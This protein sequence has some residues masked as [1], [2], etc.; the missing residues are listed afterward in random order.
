MTRR[1]ELGQYFTP[2]PVAAFA[3]DALEAFGLAGGRLRV[4]DPA[5]GEGVFLAEALRR[6]PAARVWGCDLDATLAERWRAAGLAGG[7]AMQGRG[8]APRVHLHVQDGLLDAPL[9]GIGA[10]QFDL[11]L[12]NPPYGLGL[13]R[14]GHG[15]STEALFLRRFAELA[16]RGAWLAVIVPEGIVA[17]DRAQGLRD[18][19]LDRV[20]LRAVVALPESTFSV[21]GTAARTTLLLA[22]KGEGAGGEALLASPPG[23]CSG[24]GALEGYL[25]EVLSV[26]KG[27][28][29]DAPSGRGRRA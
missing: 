20:A 7:G 14:P 29:G 22:R 10:G 3:L 21:S 27:R 25:R 6:F 24:R 12:G 28:N 16:R 18:W 5:C 26:I 2:Q 23:P 15:E 1:R 9:W 19:L 8:T 17:S 4:I 13:P 11:V